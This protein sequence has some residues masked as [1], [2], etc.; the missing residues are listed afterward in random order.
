MRIE[1]LPACDIA[2]FAIPDDPAIFEE[3]A[4]SSQLSLF[5]WDKDHEQSEEDD[6]YNEY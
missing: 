4:P 3:K 1:K 5:N 6:K 2:G